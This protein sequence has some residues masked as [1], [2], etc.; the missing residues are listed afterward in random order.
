MNAEDKQGYGLLL[1]VVAGFLIG[2]SFLVFII[3]VDLG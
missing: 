1:I 3:A 2:F